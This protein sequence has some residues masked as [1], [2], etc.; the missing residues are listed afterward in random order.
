MSRDYRI[1]VIAVILAVAIVLRLWGLDFGLPY[2]YHADERAAVGRAFQFFKTGDL[3]PRWFHWPTFYMYMIAALYFVSYL[4]GLWGGMFARPSEIPFSRYLLMGGGWA[5]VPEPFLIA[6]LTTAALGVCTVGLAY[7]VA[8]RLWGHR[9]G[10]VAALSV[11]ASSLHVANSQFATA[12]V[13]MTFMVTLSLAS[14]VRLVE[15]GHWA[16]YLMAG[17]FGGLS[18]ATKYNAL[19]IVVT[20]L[21]T[22][23]LRPGPHSVDWR[24][25]VGLGAVAVAFVIGTPYAVLDF[26]TFRAGISFDLRHYATGHAGCE[27]PDTWWWILRCLAASEGLLLPVG[28]LG[29]VAL[30]RTPSARKSLPLSAFCLAYY[31]VM[32]IQVV[33][34]SRNLVACI[35]PLAILSAGSVEVALQRAR[36]WKRASLIRAG[37]V[38][39]VAVG[40][41]LPLIQVVRRNILLCQEDVRTIAAKWISAHVSVGSCLAGESYAPTL[42]P[43]TYQLEYFGR[44]IERGPEWYKVQG[45]QYLML[46]SGMYQR[47]YMQP[48]RYPNEVAQYEALFQA[49]PTVARFTGPMM[50]SPE[51]E[52]VLLEIQQDGP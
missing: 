37:L 35:P 27:G 33:R 3:N 6:R 46:S 13:P 2:T 30:L 5:Q 8:K 44:A 40:L 36:S 23:G 19:P 34:F 26:D 11:A 49:F 4:L 31:A 15:T 32:S 22:H 38:A 42:D 52:I 24:L 43:D 48:E 12:D 7:H 47:F 28:I 14:C 18:I 29:G 39:L 9:S 1:L 20:L 50:G 25:A 10:C 17:L 41:A 51:A 21:V 16:D 45:F